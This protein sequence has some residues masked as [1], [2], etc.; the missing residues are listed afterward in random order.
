MSK[1]NYFFAQLCCS[2]LALS[3]TPILHQ[4]DLLEISNEKVEVIRRVASRWEDVATRLHFELEDISRIHK[5]NIGD[6]KSACR[7][8]FGEWLKGSCRETVTWETLIKALNESKFS[9]IAK[10]LEDYLQNCLI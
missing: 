7:Q 8:M 3:S 9:E 10:K 4:L 1:F 6:S 2:G 5:D